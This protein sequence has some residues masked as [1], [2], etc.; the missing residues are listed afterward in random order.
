MLGGICQAMYA[1]RKDVQGQ[2]QEL[3]CAL[4]ML[5]CCKQTQVSSRSTGKTGILDLQV[6]TCV[7]AYEK[8]QCTQNC[9]TGTGQQ[10]QCRYLCKYFV[11]GLIWL[12]QGFGICNSSFSNELLSNCKFA[13]MEEV[14]CYHLK[15]DAKWCQQ[16]QLAV[17]RQKK[18]WL[19]VYLIESLCIKIDRSVCFRNV[20][21]KCLL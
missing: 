9:F 11:H 14:F 12:P 2:E 15:V 4:L 17:V 13:L 3:C 5:S 20:R 21:H 19:Q 1:D 18:A 8:G 7:L 6:T 10:C 16:A